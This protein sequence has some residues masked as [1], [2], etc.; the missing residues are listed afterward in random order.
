ME[1]VADR[2]AILHEGRIV[3]I[4]DVETL[5]DE[6]KRVIMP[7]SGFEVIAN[8]LTVLD[9]AQNREEVDIVVDHAESALNLFEEWDIQPDV[10]SLN[11]EEI[12]EAFV[13]GSRLEAFAESVSLENT[14]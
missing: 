8:R 7:R 14:K 6:V 1:A 4:A 2:I 5:R 13:I 11:L 12:F 9:F 3:K 10:V